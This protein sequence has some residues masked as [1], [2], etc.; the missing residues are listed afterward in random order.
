MFAGPGGNCKTFE[1]ITLTWPLGSLGSVF[2]LAANLYHGNPNR[3]H[4]LFSIVS[5][6]TYTCVIG[7]LVHENE[8]LTFG[9]LK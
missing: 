8:K 5:Y 2:L 4:T 3:N 9:K 1:F 6:T 7:R